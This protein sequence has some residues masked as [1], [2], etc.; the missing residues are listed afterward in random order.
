MT[1]RAIGSRSAAAGELAAQAERALAAR[2]QRLV[3]R[4]LDHA[5]GW[6]WLFRERMQ[7][8]KSPRIDEDRDVECG[9]PG[10][11]DEVL[12]T[13]STLGE[14]LRELQLAKPR[15]Y[16][17]VVATRRDGRSLRDLAKITGL[18]HQQVSVELGLGE[19]YLV[20]WLRRAEVLQ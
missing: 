12:A 10:D 20:G 13:L 6:Y 4:R 16:E 3:F 15:Q 2:Q 7:A 17:I 11:P 14:A 5:L 9:P 18:S 1:V 19:S 8:P